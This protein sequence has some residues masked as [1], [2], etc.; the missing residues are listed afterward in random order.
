VAETAYD[1][2]AMGVVRV[3]CEFSLFISQQN[4]S[5]LFL[6]A[7]DDAL[8]WWYKK[9][10]AIQQQHVSKSA[11]ARVEELLARESHQLQAQ[12]I[13]KTPAAMEVQV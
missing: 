9:M 7:L 11:K 12:N 6:T 8:K 3:L 10:C 13:D 1:E 2:M 5:D 4:H